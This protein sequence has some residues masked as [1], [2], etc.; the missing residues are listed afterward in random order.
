MLWRGDC[1]YIASKHLKTVIGDQDILFQ[2]FD[3]Q[4]AHE[5]LIMLIDWLQ[6]DLQ[7]IHMALV[8]KLL[9]I[10]LFINFKNNILG[11]EKR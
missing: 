4:D 1:K 10:I 7:T 3:Q 8:S 5:F 6:S 11:H 2:G 9:I